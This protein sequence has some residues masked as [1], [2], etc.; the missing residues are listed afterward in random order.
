MREML[1][2]LDWSATGRSSYEMARRQSK[3]N[4]C[5]RFVDVSILRRFVHRIRFFVAPFRSIAPCK[6]F[7][8]ASFVLL[9]IV[10]SLFIITA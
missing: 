2:I 4:A 8:V 6:L 1:S 7:H 9:S 3:D 5:V 10:L